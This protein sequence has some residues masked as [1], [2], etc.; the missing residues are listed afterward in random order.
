VKVNAPS[1]FDPGG[2]I[3]V[4]WAPVDGFHHLAEV[5]YRQDQWSPQGFSEDSDDYTALHRELLKALGENGFRRHRPAVLDVVRIPV[6][7]PQRVADLAAM[8]CAGDAIGATA[9][10]V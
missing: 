1:V 10:R 3:A 4:V 8:P 7:V 9:R 2:G 5:R 6:D